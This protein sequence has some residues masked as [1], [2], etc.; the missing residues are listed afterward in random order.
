MFSEGAA[1]HAILA[2]LA[3]SVIHGEVN[4][5]LGIFLPVVVVRDGVVII[6][7]VRRFVVRRGNVVSGLQNRHLGLFITG[8]VV[9][10]FFLKTGVLFKGHVEQVDLDTDFGCAVIGVITV[11]K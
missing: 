4:T 8:E 1:V 7:V 10:K 9:G 6:I 5:V 3:S 11:T 2:C